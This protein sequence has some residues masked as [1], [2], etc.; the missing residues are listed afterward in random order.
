MSRLFE[1]FQKKNTA[2]KVSRVTSKTIP[3]EVVISI[4]LK[5]NA[6]KKA[7]LDDNFVKVI[8]Y[9]YAVK[10][11]EVMGIYPTPKMIANLLKSHPLS[12]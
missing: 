2:A 1:E 5:S 6:D 9:E 11:L 8:E 7:E 3:K 12:S 10:Y 4:P